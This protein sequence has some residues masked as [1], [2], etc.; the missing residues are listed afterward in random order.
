MLCSSTPTACFTPPLHNPSSS[1]SSFYLLYLPLSFLLHFLTSHPFVYAILLHFSLFSSCN[2]HQLPLLL[3]LLLPLH[4]PSCSSSFSSSS[5]CLSTLP[6]TDFSS[7]LPQLPPFLSILYSFTSHSF[8]LIMFISS[9]YSCC[10]A[11][12]PTILLHIFIFVTSHSAVSCIPILMSPSKFS[13]RA[14][15]WYCYDCLL[16]KV[17]VIVACLILKMSLKAFMACLCGHACCLLYCNKY[18]YKLTQCVHGCVHGCVVI[19][20]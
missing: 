11:S 10:I 7:S 19:M 5:S 6:P 13:V 12:S 14:S 3:L 15:L 9:H 17:I 16:A 1:S 18:A 4:N 20:S 8:L 2:V